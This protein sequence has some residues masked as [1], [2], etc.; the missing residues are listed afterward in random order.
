MADIAKNRK[1]NNMDSRVELGDIIHVGRTYFDNTDPGA[2]KYSDLLPADML[3]LSGTVVG[4]YPGG[5]LK[6]HWDVDD[7]SEVIQMSDKIT[8][9][10]PNEESEDKLPVRKPLPEIQLRQRNA[11]IEESNSKSSEQRFDSLD[12]D[13][14][15]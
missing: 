4:L 6:V 9:M 8:V 3:F 12:D 2:R 1:R 11:D 5:R 14:D 7:S 10:K 13:D 15:E